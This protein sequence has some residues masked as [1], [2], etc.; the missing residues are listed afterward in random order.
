MAEYEP[1][2]MS[3]L[4]TEYSRVTQD[5]TAPVKSDFIEKFVKMPEKNGFVLMRIM[6]RS[7][8]TKLFC[9]TRVHTL[10]NPTTKEKKTFH[11]PKELVQ[12]DRGPRWQGECIICKYYSDL[13]QQSEALSG[14]AQEDMQNRARAI[15]PVDRYY[16]N[17][18]VRSEKDKNG[19]VLKNVGPKIYSCGKTVHS[20]IM[21]AIVGDEAAGERPLGDITD[22]KT[23]RDFRVVK[24][25]KGDYPNYDESKFEDSSPVGTP[26]ELQNWLENLNDLTSLRRLSTNDELKHGLKIHLGMIVE[27]KNKDDDLAEFRT[28]TQAASTAF[29]GDDVIREELAVST[30]PAETENVEVLADSDFMDELKAM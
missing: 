7:K 25:M 16:Y 17:V 3:E 24:K 13:W 11:C 23:G 19:Q 20:K 10:Y 2:D 6:P 26:E 18:I 21:R 22:P 28:A 30:S 8:G 9:A 27:G 5:P 15:K 14:K 4:S 1:L 29:A 12:S